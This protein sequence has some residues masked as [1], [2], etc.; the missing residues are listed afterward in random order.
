MKV[1]RDRV[2]RE[3]LRLLDEVGLEE[4]TLRTLAKKLDIQ[5]ATLYWHFKSKQDLIDEMATLILAEGSPEL[6]PRKADADWSVFAAAFGTGLRKVLLRYRDGARLVTGS[7]L[8]DTRYMTVAE[9]IA[10]RIVDGG[11][12]IRQTVV[13]MST[14]NAYTQSFVMEEQ[15]VFTRPGERSAQYDLAAR[16]AALEGKGLPILIQSGPIL[17]DRF[18]RRYREGIELIIG[19]ARR[20]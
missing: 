17:F 14:I 6:L 9:S 2:L 12:T 1:N 3:A 5:A 10:K 7:R 13:L 18:D 15:A 4:L 19:G 8:T 11:F 16:K 20:G